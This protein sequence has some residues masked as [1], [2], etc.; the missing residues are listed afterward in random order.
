MDIHPERIKNLKH[1]AERANERLRERDAAAT[2]PARLTYQGEQVILDDPGVTT[3]AWIQTPDGEWKCV[4]SADLMVDKKPVVVPL[5]VKDRCDECRAQAFVEVWAT[6]WP[7]SLLFCGH[8]YNK[9]E[10]KLTESG[11]E[12]LQDTRDTINREASVSGHI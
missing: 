9:H 10:D 3:V 6:G 4:D 7:Q 8:H 5:E 12:V 11:A 1:R 2:P